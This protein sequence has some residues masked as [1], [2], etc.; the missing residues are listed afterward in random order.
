MM[1]I[2]PMKPAASAV[3]LLLGILFGSAFLYVKVIVEEISATEAVA[4]RLFL[5][6]LTLLVLLALMRRAPR[7][8]PSTVAG[9][10]VLVVLDSLIPHTLIAWAEVRIDSGIASVLVSTMPLFT[11]LFA[12][13]ALPDE[14]LGSQGLVGLAAGFAGVVVLAGNDIVNVTSASTLGMLAVVGSAASYGLAAVFARRLMRSQGALELTG[15]KLVI[16]VALAFALTFVV[17]GTPDYGA[18]SATGVLALL[19]LGILSTGVAFAVFF[20]FVQSEGSVKASLVTYIVPVVGLLLGGLVLG[21][22][23]GLSTALGSALIATGVAGVMYQP[24]SR[25]AEIERPEQP[26]PAPLAV[27]KEEYA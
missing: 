22:Q 3:L 6:A 4:G 16:G 1:N 24:S 7:L 2:G 25:T 15:L 10:T 20:W 19:A 9:A 12:S 11:V 23:I 8:T 18:L 13:V 5:G 27:A 17:N 26:C 14:R 21:E